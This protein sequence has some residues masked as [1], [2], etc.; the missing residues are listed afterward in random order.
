MTSPDDPSRRAFSDYSSGGQY[1]TE[2]FPPNQY[3]TSQPGFN[4]YPQ[5]QNSSNK[6]LIVT[7]AVVA[8]I[9]LL[10]VIGLVTWL[11]LGRSTAG[12]AS[13]ASPSAATAASE[14]PGSV[15]AP[16]PIP[17]PAPAPAAALPSTAQ[18]CGSVYGSLNGYTTSAVGSSVTSC[19]F[20]EEVRFAYASTGPRGLSRLVTAVSPVTGTVY[21]MNC[22]ANARVVTCAGGDN[23]VVYVY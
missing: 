19:P 2:S 5:P 7:L 1:P 21:D 6:G 17:A 23:A 4:R 20:A 9:A 12:P 16:A 11:L 10:A 15:E 3:P 8:G 22:V 18:S 13:S 14:Q